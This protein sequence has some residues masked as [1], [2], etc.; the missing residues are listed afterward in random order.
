MGDN[1]TEEFAIINAF[2]GIQKR[3]PFNILSSQDI[4]QII[5][6][7]EPFGAYRPYLFAALIFIADCVKD[8]N[9]LKNP[10]QIIYELIRHQEHFQRKNKIS[11]DIGLT[12]LLKDFY[13]QKYNQTVDE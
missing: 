10:K 5:K 3:S 8:V 12:P 2:S 11:T 7:L 9:F 13:F 4:E 1:V 6:T